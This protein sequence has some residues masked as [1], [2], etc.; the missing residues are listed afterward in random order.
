M[1]NSGPRRL[2]MLVPALSALALALAAPSASASA[3]LPPGHEIFQGVAGQPISSYVQA[4]GR[5]PAVYEIF[6][7]WGEYLPRIFQDAQNAHARL[8][9]HITTASGTQEM[10]T[11]RQIAQGR[12]D[13]WLIA[14]NQ[15]TYDS[16]LV[17]YV[18]L[19]AEMDGYWNVYSAYN[20]DGSWRGA[21]HSPT[22]YRNAWRRVTLIMRGGRLTAI[23]A[24]LHRLRMPPLRTHHDL[25]QPKVSMLWVPQT[26]GSP[27]ITGNE[28]RDYWPGRQWVDWVGTDFYG[29]FPN[30]AGLN[31]LYSSYPGFPFVFGEWALWGSDAPGFVDG[32]FGWI[33]AHPRA[34]MLIYNQG[35]NPVGPFRLVS[36]PRAASELRRLLASPRF[37]ALAPEFGG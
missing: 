33:G 27:D 23:D 1:T 6:S 18:R 12:G 29:K 2:A 15:A 10:I 3:F 22:A 28:P 16:G 13:A 21:S 37:P 36:Y 7:A 5:H 25:T 35:L 4:S 31:A 19:M 11:P 30:F 14:M 34:R 32:L 9:I 17:T 8:M 20:A 26:S 24:E